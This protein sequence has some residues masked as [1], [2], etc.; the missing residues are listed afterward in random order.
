MSNKYNT[1]YLVREVA[2]KLKV[3]NLTIYRRVR[4][5]RIRAIKLL[6]G[7][8]RIWKSEIDKMLKGKLIKL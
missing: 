5:G 7:R 1:F 2:E 8:W 6:N 4:E 3:S